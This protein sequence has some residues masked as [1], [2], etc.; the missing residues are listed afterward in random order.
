MK[1]LFPV[2]LVLLIAGTAAFAQADTAAL[3]AEFWFPSGGLPEVRIGSSEVDP[4]MDDLATLT[5]EMETGLPLGSTLTS[6]NG[7]TSLDFSNNNYS[8]SPAFFT[9]GF[10]E[11]ANYEALLSGGID[12]PISGTWNFQTTSDD[13]SML[14]IDGQDVVNNNFYQGPTTRGGSIY[15]TA[16]L[17]AID[18]GYF[19][20]GGGEGLLVQQEAQAP[21]RIRQFPIRS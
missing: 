12:I 5:A 8:N 13:G 19:Q 3:T 2:T 1:R 20:G 11:T 21:P 4:D 7:V 6:M 14:W 9:I 18:I 10:F 17:H 15:L 16:G